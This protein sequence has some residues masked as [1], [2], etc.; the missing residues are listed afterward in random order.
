MKT[1]LTLT[2]ALLICAVNIYSQTNKTCNHTAE[3][4]SLSISKD[5]SVET[6]YGNV[7]FDA[8]KI[9]IEGADSLVF[10]NKTNKVIA[11]NCKKYTFEG[12]TLI[13]DEKSNFSRLEYTFGD[14]TI[15]VK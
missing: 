1:K 8:A 4:K 11:Y 9:N 14:S 2:G 13:A 3:G 5:K 10:N 12:Q 6:W 7:M 15:Y